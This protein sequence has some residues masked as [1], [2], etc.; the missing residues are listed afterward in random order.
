M[1]LMTSAAWPPAAGIPREAREL[2]ARCFECGAG[3]MVVDEGDGST[4]WK[5]MKEEVA[6][7]VPTCGTMA[8]IWKDEVRIGSRWT[9][10]G[11]G[12]KLEIGLAV[13]KMSDASE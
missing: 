3:Y 1:M 8:L 5:P 11:C 13:A 9:C 6:C 2:E 7:P 10:E 12:H 4:K